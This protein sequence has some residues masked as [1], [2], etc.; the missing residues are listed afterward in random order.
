M[1]IIYLLDG[2]SWHPSV[3]AVRG[4]SVFISCVGFFVCLLV[5][6]CVLV[7]LFPYMGMERMVPCSCSP[8]SCIY[9]IKLSLMKYFTDQDTIH[10]SSL[11]IAIS[12]FSLR[13]RIW[14]NFY[15][16]KLARGSLTASSM[17]PDCQLYDPWLPALWSLTGK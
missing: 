13:N 15:P 4:S 14:S 5:C 2:S 8:S 9:K 3:P 7:L 16:A 1:V 11:K 12:M 17:I 6:L 10:H